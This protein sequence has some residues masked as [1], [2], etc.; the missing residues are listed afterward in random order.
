MQPTIR[1]IIRHN[2]PLS[3]KIKFFYRFIKWQFI[4]KVLKKNLVFSFTPDSKLMLIDGFQ[5]LSGNYYFGVSEP[6]VMPF[7]LHVL[8]PND[9]LVDI[10]ANGGA[11]TILASG[12]K[13][14][15]T[16]CIEAA[17][18]TFNGLIKNVSLNVLGDL[19][20]PWNVAVSDK[21]GYLPFTT[22]DH[23]TNRVSYEDRPDIIN[24][25]AK[26]LDNILA[27]RV[28]LV[29]KMDIEGHEHNALLGAQ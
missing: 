29:I 13:K 24:V 25:K 3:Q 1:Q 16:V 11:Y 14:A 5:A 2:Y 19:V 4:S 6:D 12:E 17:P 21:E 9:L 26:T 27:D 8:H 22:S 10:G 15:R 7:V 28:P 20:E 23:A 18:D